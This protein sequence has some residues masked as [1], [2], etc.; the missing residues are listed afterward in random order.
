ML[1]EPHTNDN[2]LRDNDRDEA[3]LKP[4]ETTLDLP[5]VKDIP[6]QEHVRP[7]RI[8]EMEDITVSSA[9]EE[10]DG[11]FDEENEAQDDDLSSEEDS[12]AVDGDKLSQNETAQTYFSN[13]Q[14]DGLFDEENELAD[15]DADV[16]DTERELLEHAA[17]NSD[18]DEERERRSILPDNTD[19][20][21]EPLNEEVNADGGD[22]DVPGSEEDDENE[23]LG[24]EDEENNSYSLGGDRKD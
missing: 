8:R 2:D 3:Y 11:L 23:E 10:G 4:E 9:D 22:L 14:A 16:S 13:A 6:G 5:D 7:P 1:I 12:I 21:G 18:S 19:D 17:D 20:E 24:E 15:D